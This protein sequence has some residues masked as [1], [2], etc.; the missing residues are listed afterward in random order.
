MTVPDQT[1]VPGVFDERRFVRVGVLCPDLGTTLPAWQA[2]CLSRLFALD[3]VEAALKIVE[4]PR[5]D[6]GSV[7]GRTPRAGT[8]AGLLCRLF[9]AFADR[10]A[11]ALRPA[12]VEPLLGQLPTVSLP[13]GQR[14]VATGDEIVATIRSANL[15]LILHFGRNVVPDDVASLPRYGTW[16]FDFDEKASAGIRIGFW[17]VYHGNAVTHASLCQLVPPDGEAILCE[18]FFKTATYSYPRTRNTVLLGV[19]EWPA[20]VCRQLLANAMPPAAVRSRSTSN[21]QSATNRQMVLLLLR[22]AVRFAAAAAATLLRVDHWNI[23]IVAVP[24]DTFLHP[25]AGV[26]IRWLPEPPRGW[27]VADPFAPSCGLESGLLVEAFDYRSGKGKIA[28]VDAS[29]STAVPEPVIAEPI[30]LSYP[31]LLEHEGA[32]YCVPDTHQARAVHLYQ[33]MAFPRQWV[34]RATLIEGFVGIDA[35]IVRHDGLWWLFCSEHEELP[36]HTLYV[37]YAE[38]LTGPWAPHVANPVKVDVRSSRP[39]GTPFVHEGRL[40]RPAQDCSRIYGGAVVIN[41]VSRLTPTEYHEEAG[42]VI[43]PDVTGPYP[44]GLHTLSACGRCTLVD[45]KRHR[46]I[47]EMGWSLPFFVVERSLAA[48]RRRTGAPGS[49]PALPRGPDQLR[50]RR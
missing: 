24:I 38:D 3:R 14:P 29:D 10:R 4:T 25:E 2:R 5:A 43:E 30:H 48:R 13:A 49:E 17:E 22:S 28:T 47:W 37:W 42:T 1:A 33:A 16:A 46:F 36:N 50:H 45:G 11:R 20:R 15:D 23:G 6:P 34:R 12:R 18:G 9:H 40:Y 31:F 41:H 44:R 21:R 39:A 27:Y 7:N 35:S 19:A 8:F 32:I 26:P